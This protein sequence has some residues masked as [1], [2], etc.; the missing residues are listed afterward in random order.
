MS[1]PKLYYSSESRDKLKSSTIREQMSRY[2]K[3][4]IIYYTN[5][6]RNFVII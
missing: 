3:V 2:V 1:T 5:S 6:F 4:T